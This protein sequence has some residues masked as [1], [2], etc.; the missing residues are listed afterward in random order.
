M[1][2]YKNVA[3]FP[4]RYGSKRIKNKNIKLINHKPILKITFEIIKKSKLFD[5]IVLSSDSDRIL[6]IGKKI[7]FDILSKRPKRISGDKVGTT[8]VIQYEIKKLKEKIIFENVCCIYPT[9][10]FIEKKFLKKAFLA[11][12]KNKNAFIFPVQKYNHPIERSFEIVNKI[13]LKFSRENFKSRRTQDLKPKVHDAGQF[14]LAKTYT[15]FKKNQK[16]L[17]GIKIPRF[18]SFDIDTNQD[19]QDAKALIRFKKF[20]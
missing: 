15:W 1:K 12:K 19:L 4:A 17:F 5:L 16:N 18:S 2:K 8:K 13:K 14:Y 3:I 20:K 7:G 11:L 10:I 9:G 6:K